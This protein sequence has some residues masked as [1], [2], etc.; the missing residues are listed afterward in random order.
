MDYWHV[1]NVMLSRGFV[2]FLL[3]GNR[4]K[5]SK[6]CRMNDKRDK[7]SSFAGHSKS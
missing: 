7:H 4:K 1:F 3:A 6:Q 5:I 2:N